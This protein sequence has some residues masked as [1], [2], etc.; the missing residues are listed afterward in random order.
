M[1]KYLILLFSLISVFGYTQTLHPNSGTTA[2]SVNNANT[3]PTT[4]SGTNT[5]TATLPSAG[6]ITDATNFFTDITDR[7]IYYKFTNAA[8]SGPFTLNLNSE[9]AKDLKKRDA[10]GS[11]VDI[12]ATDI[13]AGQVLPIRYNGTYLVIEGGS[14]GSVSD[15]GDI[16]GTLSDQTDLQSAL[17]LKQDKYPSTRTVTNSTTL[18]LTD[19]GNAVEMNNAG[20]TTITVPEQSSVTWLSDTYVTLINKGA[21]SFTVTP[22]SGVTFINYSGSLV[23]GGA[24]AIVVLKRITS[25]QWYVFNGSPASVSSVSGTTNRITSSGGLTPIIDISSSYAGQA[26]IVTTGII[27]SNASNSHGNTGTWTST[28]NNQYH[29]REN[30][31]LTFRN[32]SSDWLTAKR[33]SP[34]FTFT[35]TNQVASALDIESSTSGVFS[36]TTSYGLRVLESG[37][38][39]FQ[40]ESNGNV[41]FMNSSGVT[42]MSWL[43][44]GVLT[45]TDIFTQISPTDQTSGWAFFSGPKNTTGSMFLFR[46]GGT[47]TLTSGQLD[48]ITLRHNGV[49]EWAPT[50]GTNTLTIINAYPNINQTGTASGALRFIDWNPTL[51]SLLGTHYGIT[52]RPTGALNGFGIASPTATMHVVGT[53]KLDGTVTLPTVG[54]KL[55]IKEGSGGFMG[56]T[57][58]VS[59]TKA[60]TVSGVTTS[61]RCFLTRTTPSGTTLT[62]DYDCVCTANTVTIQA[63]VAAG[64]IN[65]ADNSTFN[66]LL[67]EPAP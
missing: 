65:T 55:S 16:G 53:T 1:K 56:S 20:S 32:T 26:S 19:A 8:T 28:A 30:P 12:V 33:L 13:A 39:R 22:G 62:T 24:G 46:S 4:V 2:L 64:T 48:W 44:S 49:N 11:I 43:N 60:V 9:G 47:T 38:P 54:N 27:T 37:S 7:L 35:A 25:D 59:G 31:T 34:S 40:V 45:T 42:Q 50:S 67:I 3:L 57:S 15:W 14:G 58:L 61:T 52:I 17:D 41:R 5:Y 10:T 66:Y 21:G 29:S 23:S 51:T 18:L 36:G 6:T 63:D